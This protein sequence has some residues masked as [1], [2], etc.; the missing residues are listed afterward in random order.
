M[1]SP[2][3]ISDSVFR[4]YD[5]RGI[6]GR[7][8]DVEGAEIIGRSFANY[9]LSKNENAKNIVVGIDGRVTSPGLSKMFIY[10]ILTSGLNVV[11]IGQTTTPMLYFSICEGEFDGGA[12]ITA[13]HNSKEYNGFKLCSKDAHSISGDEIQELRKISQKRRFPRVKE[14]GEETEGSFLAEYIK[15][16]SSVVDIDSGGKEFVDIS[17][18]GSG[19][20]VVIDAGNGVAGKFAPEILKSFGIEVIELYCY[21]DGIFPNRDPNCDSAIILKDLSDKVISEEADFGIAFDGDGDRLGMVDEKGNFISAD[22][23]LFILCKDFLKK[24]KKNKKIVLDVSISQVLLNE[25]KKLK[26]EAVLSRTGHSFMEQKMKEES[27]LLGGEASGHFFFADNYFGFD[28]AMLAAL[29]IIEIFQ[30]SGLEKFSYLLQDFPRIFS[31]GEISIP[32]SD[33]L[34]FSVVEKVVNFFKDKYN[35]ITID[36]VRIDFGDGSWGLVRASNTSPKISVRFEA[37]TEEKL[38]KVEEVILSHLKKYREL[39]F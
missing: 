7:D 32:C 6:A 12:V 27:S 20:K 34:K 33:E 35:C 11:N 39:S 8:F 23:I 1:R 15:K 3:V 10:G 22:K 38:K 18:E 16:L 25:I 21:V 2:T 30:E 37:K 5:I 24:K 31:S 9:I 4:A 17:D 29:K 13:S 14:M 26:G 19:L 28:D 36:G